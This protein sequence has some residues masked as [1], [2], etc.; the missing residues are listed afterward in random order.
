MPVLRDAVEQQRAFII[1]KLIKAGIF[2][3]AEL[4]TRTLT[5]TDLLSIYEKHVIRKE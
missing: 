3:Q 5:L 4:D 2:K 1:K